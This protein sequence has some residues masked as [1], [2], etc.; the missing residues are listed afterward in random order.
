[1]LQYF[2]KYSSVSVRNMVARD[3]PS[4]NIL[5]VAKSYPKLMAA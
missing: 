4:V 2:Q 1:M 5:E 3:G